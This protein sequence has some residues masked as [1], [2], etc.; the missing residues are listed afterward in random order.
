MS[1]TL[2]AARTQVKTEIGERSDV[3][4]LIDDQYNYAIQELCTMY[5]HPVLQKSATMTT[6]ANEYFYLLPSDYHGIKG[7]YDETNDREIIQ[8]PKWSFESVNE[9]TETGENGPRTYAIYNRRL[10]LWNQIPSVSTISI[11]ID[12]WA[13]HGELSADGDATLLPLLWH[14][15]ARLKATAFT[16]RILNMDD[17]AAAREQEFDRWLGRIVTSRSK[18]DTSAR[19]SRIIWSR[20]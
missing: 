9:S 20:G 10:F 6:T 5:E 4:D 14:R 18:E 12:Y 1:D 8:A 2:L 7:V 3:D 13:R 15:G 19:D 16:M 11:R 17:K